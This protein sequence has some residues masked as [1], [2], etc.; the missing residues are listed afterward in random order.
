MRKLLIAA[1]G[2]LVVLA[3]AVYAI[4]VRALPAELVRAQIEQRLAARLGQPVRIGSASASILPRVA[5]DLHDVAIGAPASVRLSRVSLVTGVRALFSRRIEDAEV[6]V[7]DGRV[8]WPL[9]FSLGSSSEAAETS[10]SP[11]TI[12]NVR[13]IQFRRVTLATAFPPVTI[14]LD[15][16]LEGDRLEISH[17]A[18]KSDR[19]TLEASGA[20]TS[21][22]QLQGR[23]RV[24]GELTFAGYAAR[25]FAA[26]VAFS[27]QK[28]SLS[29]L[30][31]G[32]FGGTFDG[33]LDLDLRGSTPQLQLKGDVAK[34]DVAEVMK[35]TGSTGGITGRLAGVMALASA[36]NDGLS[37]VRAAR[38]TFRANVTDG[39]LPYLNIVR[40]VVLAFGKPSGQTPQGSGS[41]FSS[42]S[43]AFVL[44]NSTVTTDNLAL[45]ARDFSAH[46]RAALHVD[47]GA[48]DSHLDVILSQELTSQSG[49][50]LRRYAAEN[51][52]VVVPATVGGTLT[53][54]SVFVDP[55]AAMRRAFSNEIQR[56]AKS[57]LDGLFKKKGKGDD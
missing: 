27:P 47:T 8:V 41:S 22:A 37:L 54:P 44:A 33:R 20:V 25:N 11:L 1:V 28:V 24:K 7:D 48:V 17:L 15:A 4:A 2:V 42:L 5:I 55:A 45:E 3:I 6:L 29:P 26:D 57:L 46:G 40:P 31:F 53:R 12:A 52:R 36:G 9:P 34:V 23:F 10:P 32:M 19:N 50:D 16:S 13:R 56:K 38:G 35:N 51:G 39:T 43:G 49:T 21:V 30:A 18:A 14:D